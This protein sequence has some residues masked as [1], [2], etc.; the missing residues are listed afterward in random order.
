MFL[1]PSLTFILTKAGIEALSEHMVEFLPNGTPIHWLLPQYT[2]MFHTNSLMMV[3]A[4]LADTP[5]CGCGMFQAAP[6]QPVAGRVCDDGGPEGSS[7]RP[8][9]TRPCWAH[10][11]S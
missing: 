11:V 8:Y 5:Q 2:K 6:R 7:G 1:N 9:C 10:H 4:V 3:S